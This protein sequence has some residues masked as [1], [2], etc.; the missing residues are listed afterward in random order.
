MHSAKRET[1]SL[2]HIATNNNVNHCVGSGVAC[3]CARGFLKEECRALG[4]WLR[5]ADE[6]EP[7]EH[8]GMV[9]RYTEGDTRVGTRYEQLR[10][11]G[12]LFDYG[13]LAIA[14]WCRHWGV[15]WWRM[16]L[17][18]DSVG[19]LSKPPEQIPPR[20]PRVPHVRLSLG[21]PEP[22]GLVVE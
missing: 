5:D 4:H 18:R 14:N 11:R 15:P 21:V 12:R 10:L 3:G 8:D 9:L 17:T 22:A 20:A 19:I 13:R 2:K 16:P 1:L 6:D 7:S